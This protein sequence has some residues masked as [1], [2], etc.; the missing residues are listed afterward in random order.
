MPERQLTVTLTAD[1]DTYGPGEEATFQVQVVDHEG[2]PVVAEVSLA[3]VDEAIYAL[4]E[5]MSKDPFDVFYAPRP[6]IVSNLRLAATRPAGSTPR[7]RAWAA[8]T[9]KRPAR[10]A[11]TFSTPP[12]GRRPSSPARMAGRR[13]PSPCPTT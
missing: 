10:P 4:A 3:V 8:A 9:A 12:T 7:G 6:N 5:D 13:S 2:Q 1:Q 11:A